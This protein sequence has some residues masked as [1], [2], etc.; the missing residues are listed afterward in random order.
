MSKGRIIAILAVVAVLIFGGFQWYHY[1]GRRTVPPPA[2]G[3]DNI[4]VASS[5]AEGLDVPWDMGF[6]PDKS[7]VFTEIT[8]DVRFIDSSGK[9][10]TQPILT[11]GDVAQVG[12]GGLLGIALHPQFSTNGW[13][14]FYYTY[15]S[16]KGLAN[17]VVRYT[18]H[19]NS[20]TQR[21]VIIEDIP[22]DNI[23][24]GGRIEF[25]PDGLLY[26][27]T[28]DTGVDYLA[29]DLNSLAG[30]ILRL[31]DDGSIPV[32]N[33]FPNSA[34]YSYGHR[35]PAGLAWDNHGQLWETEQGPGSQDEINL[36]APGQNYGWPVIHGDETSAGMVSPVFQSEGDTWT[37][38]G[39]AFLNG[40]LYFSGLSSQSF[41]SFDINTRILHQYLSGNFGRLSDAVLGP[42][43]LLFI[44]TNNRD[45]RGIP[46][47]GDDRL[48]RINPAKLTTIG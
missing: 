16:G 8:G 42:S 6:L 44:F 18:M 33:P 1:L 9:L 31:N 20:F 35:N 13:I 10:Q 17:R 40:V 28:G 21:T 2:T 14:Y 5:L 7:I 43:G 38:S 46:L 27:C 11:M 37:P 47:T 15:Q 39:L 36:I 12:E 29:Q 22:G 24:D 19:G 48:L 23:H 26:I 25:G 3:N 45:G 32:N 30:K 4:P 34:I 41:F